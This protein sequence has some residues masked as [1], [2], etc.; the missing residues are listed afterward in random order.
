[1]TATA[2]FQRAIDLSD[3]SGAKAY[4]AYAHAVSGRSREAGKILDELQARAPQEYIS[5]FDI[6]AAYTGLG[7]RDRAFSWLEKAYQ[8]RV[9]PMPSLKVDPLFDPLHADPRFAALIERMGLFDTGPD[10]SRAVLP[11]RPRQFSR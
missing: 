2:E 10:R 8:E 9:R 4:L 1:M 11:S 6:A 3:S 7:N 5:P